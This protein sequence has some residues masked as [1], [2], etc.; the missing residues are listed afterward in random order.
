M[1]VLKTK[2]KCDFIPSV[3]NCWRLMSEGQQFLFQQAKQIKYLPAET[4]HPADASQGLDW[5]RW[6]Q[7]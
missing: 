5:D 3:P 6:Q 4:L 7:A 2:Y 1:H